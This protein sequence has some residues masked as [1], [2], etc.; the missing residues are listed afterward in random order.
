MRRCSIAPLFYGDVP[1]YVGSGTRDRR[2]C[3]RSER[4]RIDER[5]LLELTFC[6]KRE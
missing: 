1:H 5:G 4:K 6:L 3:S 2:A